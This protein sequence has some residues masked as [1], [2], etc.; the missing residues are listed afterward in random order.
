MEKSFQ[1]FYDAYEAI[2]KKKMHLSG[3]Q[4]AVS[5]TL[6]YILYFVFAVYLT[7]L[8]HWLVPVLGENSFS[9][10]NYYIGRKLVCST[11]LGAKYAQN[12]SNGKETESDVTITDKIIYIL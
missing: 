3:T 11:S 1:E 2:V 12:K 5:R 8:L 10:T 6:L 4:M 7:M 9:H